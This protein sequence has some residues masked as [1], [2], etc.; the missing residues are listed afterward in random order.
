MRNIRIREICKEKG[1]TLQDAAQMLGIS[2]NSLYAIMSGNP[3]L[4]TL[5]RIA[6]T[7]N[8]PIMELFEKKEN[9]ATC[10]HCGKELRIE[11]KDKI[12]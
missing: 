11:L 12:T 6:T 5:E 7:F 8:I 9:V 4:D 2:Y 10:P 1:V 3:T